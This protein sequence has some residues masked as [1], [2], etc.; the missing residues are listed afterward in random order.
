[1]KLNKVLV[2]GVDVVKRSVA[3]VAL[4]GG[5]AVGL[6]TALVLPAHADTTAVLTAITGALADI[7]T[8]GTAILGVVVAIVAFS[9]IRRVLK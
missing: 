2:G 8:V 7:G 3:R 4:V 1:M 6:S 9:W 5:T